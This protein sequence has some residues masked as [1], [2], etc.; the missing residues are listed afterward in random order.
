[1]FIYSRTLQHEC[2]AHGL[3]HLWV[4]T[5]PF[6]LSHGQFRVKKSQSSYLLQL[7]FLTRSHFALEWA[8]GRNSLSGV[9]HDA[10]PGHGPTL[11]SISA[12]WPTGP[13]LWQQKVSQKRHVTWLNAQSD[14]LQPT[15]VVL[16]NFVPRP[17]NG[18]RQLTPLHRCPTRISTGATVKLMNQE[19]THRC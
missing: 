16:G 8:N 4:M 19:K 2:H 17:N 5:W 9:A 1:M 6:S 11:S 3:A 10:H 14:G 7:I 18:T 13:E 12:C 15:S